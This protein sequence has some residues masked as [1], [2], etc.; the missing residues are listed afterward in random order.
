MTQVS[1]APGRSPCKV[2]AKG[3][4]STWCLGL[5]KDVAKGPTWVEAHL[6]WHLRALSFGEPVSFSPKLARMEN[7]LPVESCKHDPCSWGWLTS[8]RVAP[9]LSLLTASWH[10]PVNYK[11]GQLVRQAAIYSASLFSCRHISLPSTAGLMKAN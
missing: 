8:T 10:E 6:I 4:P 5:S 9:A 7:G 3:C 11:E 2:L 1:K